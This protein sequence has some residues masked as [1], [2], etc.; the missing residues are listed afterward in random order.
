MHFISTCLQEQLQKQQ[1]PT[2][3]KGRKHLY[4]KFPSSSLPSQPVRLAY[5][6]H[7][8]RGYPLCCIL[9]RFDQGEVA[10]QST[11]GNYYHHT[12]TILASPIHEKQ[13]HFYAYGRFLAS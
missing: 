11:S 9:V 13:D 3:R 6:P 5:R 8:L 7:A 10:N 12:R 4:S 2:Q 1:I